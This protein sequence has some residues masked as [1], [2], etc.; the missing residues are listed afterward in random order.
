MTT[1]PGSAEQVRLE[2]GME[3]PV[4]YHLG[5]ELRSGERVTAEIAL[6]EQELAEF[7]HIDRAFWQWQERLGATY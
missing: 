3:C 2:V 5:R 7:R 1:T 6:T 4:V